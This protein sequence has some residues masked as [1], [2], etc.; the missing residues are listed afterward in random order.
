MMRRVQVRLGGG[1]DYEIE[2]GAGALAGVGAT[3]RRALAPQARR[4]AGI[5]KQ[6]VFD[7]YGAPVVEALRAQ[8]FA[9]A[10]ALIGG[11]ERHKSLRVG[12]CGLGVLGAG[13]LE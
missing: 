4:V 12:G 9:V 7:L 13:G 8:D 3:A 11:G 6:R 2:I 5:S 1:R 10:R